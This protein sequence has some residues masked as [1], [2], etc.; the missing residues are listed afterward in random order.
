MQNLDATL[1]LI[2]VLKKKNR[3]TQAQREAL[4]RAPRCGSTPSLSTRGPSA[5]SG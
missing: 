5:P 2:P 1:L 4:E 3:A